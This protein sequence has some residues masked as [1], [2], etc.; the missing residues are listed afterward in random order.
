MSRLMPS[1]SSVLR[2][3]QET[4]ERPLLDQAAIQVE[5]HENCGPA[6][7]AFSLGNISVLTSVELPFSA[8]HMYP[9]LRAMHQISFSFFVGVYGGGGFVS[10]LTNDARGDEHD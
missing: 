7:T 2:D 3:R 10:L 8:E 4:S 9:T 5:A 6:L 1:C